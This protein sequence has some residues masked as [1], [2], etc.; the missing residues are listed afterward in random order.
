MTCPGPNP[1]HPP[2]TTITITSTS[3]GLPASKE[4]G[5]TIKYNPLSTWPSLLPNLLPQSLDP[6][7]GSSFEYLL[8]NW[9]ISNF[10][11]CG[12]VASQMWEE[13]NQLT[14]RGTKPDW[15][16]VL[17]LHGTVG[18]LPAYELSEDILARICSEANN[19]VGVAGRAEIIPR[20]IISVL[21]AWSGPYRGPR[22]SSM[23]LTRLTSIRDQVRLARVR[24]SVA[25]LITG[26]DDD[27]TFIVTGNV[28]V[29]ASQ[30]S[31]SRFTS[32]TFTHDI[33]TDEFW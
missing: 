26:C 25:T 17:R 9:T 12:I 22:V 5:A 28:T 7:R 30:L 10:V 29:L 6:L 2:A 24:R 18:L 8:S 21:H 11:L 4:V 15:Q 32:Y 13:K 14:K 23:S 16:W 19:L 31:I 27:V 20:L 1:S 33:S 3:T